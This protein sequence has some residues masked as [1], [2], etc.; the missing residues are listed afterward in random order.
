MRIYASRYGAHLLGHC[1]ID[2]TEIALFYTHVT[3]MP[4]EGFPQSAFADDA[5]V[6]ERPCHD[7]QQGHQDRCG[8][9]GRLLVK[10]NTAAGVLQRRQGPPDYPIVLRH[11][12]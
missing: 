10:D 1:Q 7:I 2:E 6:V 5:R 3:G 9:G 4:L 12:D 11:D 8:A